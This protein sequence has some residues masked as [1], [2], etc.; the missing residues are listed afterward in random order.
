MTDR[1]T[2]ENFLRVISG[3]TP[4][5][6]DFYADWCGPCRQLAPV[7]EELSS[8]F[9]GEA[10]VAKLDIDSNPQAVTKYGVRSVPT[11]LFFKDGEVVDRLVGNQPKDAV[12]ARLRALVG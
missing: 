8:E 10:R 5:L 1:L 11:L 2:D 6:V 9:A 4:T 7:I 3:P 12:A